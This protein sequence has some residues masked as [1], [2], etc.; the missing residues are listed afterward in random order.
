[1]KKNIKKKEDEGNTEKFMFFIGISSIS[2][3][4][5]RI[6]FM[7]NKQKLNLKMR[8]LVFLLGSIAIVRTLGYIGSAILI[9]LG[10]FFNLFTIVIM[11]LVVLGVNMRMNYIEEKREA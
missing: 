3:N 6:E 11:G 4:M 1:M 5:A 9:S 2:E 8:S 10:M 7:M